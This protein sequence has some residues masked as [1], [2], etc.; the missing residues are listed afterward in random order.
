MLCY[1]VGPCAFRGCNAS[2]FVKTNVYNGKLTRLP[3]CNDHR[4]VI[5]QTHCLYKKIHQLRQELYNN[6]TMDGLTLKK[7]L[8]HLICLELK[9]R[10]LM[11]NQIKPIYR[12]EGHTHYGHELLKELEAVRKLYIPNL[13]LTL[14]L[15]Y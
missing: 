1:G 14:P 3:T 11:S 5:R 6:N 13:I 4:E 9:G 8:E 12:D 15:Q 10:V 7:Q 2:C